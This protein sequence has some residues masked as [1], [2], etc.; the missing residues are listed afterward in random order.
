MP[1]ASHILSGM[2][3]RVKSIVVGDHG[4][5]QRLGEIEEPRRGEGGDGGCVKAEESRLRRWHI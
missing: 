5:G 4:R 2:H 1:R 3:A